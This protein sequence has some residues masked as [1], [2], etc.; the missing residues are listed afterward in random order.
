MSKLLSACTGYDVSEQELD[1]AGE[2]IWNQLR[3]I[4]VRNHGRN[5]EIDEST[6]DGFMYPA[7]DDGVMLDRERFLPLLSKYYELSGW[8]TATG[9][10][11]RAKLEEL[12]M[13]DVADGLEL[14]AGR[15]PPPAGTDRAGSGQ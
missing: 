3:A 14:L 7:K 8:D 15:L 4:D 13:G 9:W 2:R 10:P 6:I 12:G 11:T 1:L 5:R